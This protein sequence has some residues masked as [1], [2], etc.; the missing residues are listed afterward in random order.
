MRPLVRQNFLKNGNKCPKS[1]VGYRR[2]ICQCQMP[3]YTRS[4]VTHNSSPVEPTIHKYPQICSQIPLLATLLYN[5]VY[6]G[7]E[8]QGSYLY[9]V[10]RK[11]AEK[12]QNSVHG[13]R[14]TRLRLAKSSEANANPFTKVLIPVWKPS[15]ASR[16][17]SCHF[18]CVA[19]QYPLV[20]SKRVSTFKK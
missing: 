9:T 10:Y 2:Q 7:Y 18:I 14:R 3:C 20:I 1:D 6:P 5:T 4:P 13:D 19:S 11:L 16:M 17:L 12:K 8:H 15:V